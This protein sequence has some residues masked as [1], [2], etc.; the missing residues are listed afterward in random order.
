ME[1]IN[2]KLHANSDEEGYIKVSM[3]LSANAQGSRHLTPLMGQLAKGF[4]LLANNGYAN[5]IE[6]NM[7][8]RRLQDDIMHETIRSLPIPSSNNS[9]IMRSK[10][11]IGTL[12]R[13]FKLNHAKHFGQD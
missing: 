10:R 11:S 12:M 1:H 3:L 2:E 7:S 8:A 6:Q 4:E 9:A 13:R 5:Q